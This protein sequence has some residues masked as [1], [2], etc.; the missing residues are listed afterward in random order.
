MSNDQQELKTI[1]LHELQPILSRTFGDRLIVVRYTT[2]NLLQPGENY[3]STIFSVHAVIKRNDEAEEEDL[4]L[5]AKMPPPT[6]FQRQ[7]F[8]TPFTFKKEIFMYED[9]VPYYQKLE[10]EMGLKENEVFDILPKYYKSRLSLSP[11][12]EFDDNAVILMENLRARGYYNSNRATGCDLEHSRVAIRALARF[13]ALGMATK[14]KRPE[15]FEV[16]KERSK[17][18]EI[19]TEDFEHFREDM[20][21]RIAEDPELSVYV[22]RCDTAIRDSFKYGFWT[23]TPD[24][25]WSTIIHA[26]FWVNN[27]MFHR[28]ENDH[29]DDIK[30]VDFQNYLFFSPMRELVFF[31]FS[32][33]EVVSSEDHI[34]ELI[35]LYHETFIA[36]LNRMGCNTEP[37]TR[38]KFDA[39]LLTDA[40]LESMHLFFMLKILT[41]NVQE[42]ELKHDNMKDFMMTYQGNQ[43]FIQRLRTVIFYFIKHNWM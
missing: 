39:K 34:E 18:V 21:K 7:I 4:Y 3:G 15:Y 23:M 28:D 10:E 16:L 35:D 37:F 1:E 27:I 12:V 25:P 38:E 24:E 41:L 22:D 33:T 32:S 8:D 29:V 5:I 43:L 30:F 31:L 40:R 20:L 11:N 19:K 9:I 42:T 26:D 2:E 6:E 36:V 17:C 13:H 14:Y